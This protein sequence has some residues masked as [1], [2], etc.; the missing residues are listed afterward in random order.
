MNKKV[1]I[2]LNCLEF[3]FYLMFLLLMGIQ[4][5]FNVI[6]GLKIFL[7][8][9]ISIFILLFVSIDLMLFILMKRKVKI[10]YA[11]YKLAEVSLALYLNNKII[12]IGFLILLLF[13]LCQNLIRILFVKKIYILSKYRY[14][15]KMFKIKDFSKVRTTSTKKKLIKENVKIP[16]IKKKKKSI[17]CQKATI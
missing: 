10:L 2:Y 14:Y 13:Q 3:T 6:L 5:N 16:T 11:S 9:L 4:F 12:Y 17:T 8:F 15:C 1:N 7:L